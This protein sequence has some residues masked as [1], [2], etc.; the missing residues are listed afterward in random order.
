MISA[1][2]SATHRAAGL[3]CPFPGVGRPPAAAGTSRRA[4]THG[5]YKIPPARPAAM[6]SAAPR[7]PRAPR[8]AE[9]PPVPDG[10]DHCAGTPGPGNH[11]IRCGPVGAPRGQVAAPAPRRGPPTRPRRGRRSCLIPEV[12]SRSAPMS[13]RPAGQPGRRRGGGQARH[14][15]GVRDG[16][17]QQ[18]DPAAS[19]V[20]RRWLPRT[21]CPTVRARTFPSRDGIASH[22]VMETSAWRRAAW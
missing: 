5:I 8:P 15:Q 12:A 13:R 17:P 7:A 21:F 11:A 22:R 9:R 1:S 2:S 6:M 4:V 10:P 14:R 16:H 18:R 20:A 19:G 3:C